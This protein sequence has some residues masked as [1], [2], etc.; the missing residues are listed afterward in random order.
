V[1]SFLSLVLITTLALLVIFI[2]LVYLKAPVYRLD[3]NNLVSLFELALAGEATESDWDVFLEVPI[4]YDDELEKIRLECV[5]LTEKEAAFVDSKR[6]LCLD[7]TA[8]A[9]LTGF[10]KTLS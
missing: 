1:W 7:D 5:E 6:R 4:R 2:G 3:K 9:I 10:V 8:R